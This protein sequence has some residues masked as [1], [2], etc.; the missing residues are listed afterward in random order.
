VTIFLLQTF[1]VIHVFSAITLVGFIVFNTVVLQPALK[2]IPPAHSAVVS[3]KIGFGLMVG[4]M[5]SLFLLGATGI[6]R[7]WLMGTLANLASFDF[8]IGPYGR[9]IA[10]MILGWAFLMV[11]GI[12]SGYWYQAV[13]TKKLEY[14][15]GL[16]D[17]EEKR[18]AQELVTLWQDRLYYWNVV[19]AV[20]AALGGA[21]T[22]F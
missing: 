8:V 4:G 14:S 7:L 9:W 13:L 5:A 18:A 12:L 1:R 10:L 6:G 16:R 15:A 20:A 21:M 22:K 11:T 19:A 17:L 3:Q 2:R